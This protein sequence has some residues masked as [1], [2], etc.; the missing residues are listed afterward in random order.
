MRWE[1]PR[2][3]GLIVQHVKHDAAVAGQ[4]RERHE[5]TEGWV[6]R[7]GAVKHKDYFLVPEEW[8]AQPGSV[9]IRATAKFIPGDG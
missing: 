3:D 1:P 5:F 2:A 6:V 7:D 4:P 8:L 9:R